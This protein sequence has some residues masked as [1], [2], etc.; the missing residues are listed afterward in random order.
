MRFG[1]LNR[2]NLTSGAASTFLNQNSV[3]RMSFDL[4]NSL[5]WI[6]SSWW[7]MIYRKYVSPADSLRLLGRPLA[8]W[9]HEKQR[10]YLYRLCSP[11]RR[12]CL[13]GGLLFPSLHPFHW[14]NLAT[15]NPIGANSPQ[16]PAAVT[17]RTPDSGRLPGLPSSTLGRT[18][19]SHEFYHS[20]RG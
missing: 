6:L 10:F 8:I 4:S 3:I 5:S 15:A 20:F 18:R 7:T 2:L 9:C 11:G 14:K 12:R 1:E 13:G 16:W 17:R 19:C